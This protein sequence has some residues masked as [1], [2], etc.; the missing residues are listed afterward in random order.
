MMVAQVDAP[1]REVLP[2]AR[3]VAPLEV[4]ELTKT[5]RQGANTVTALCDFS[6]VVQ[7]DEFVAIMGASGSGKSTLL[8]VMAGIT[9]PDAGTVRI[10]GE[11]MTTMRDPQLTRFR[12]RHIGLVFQA[13]NLI[14]TLSA[15]DNVL[16]PGPSGD[17][18]MPM[19][20]SNASVWRIA[21]TTFPT[22]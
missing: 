3:A 8:N 12:R 9:R 18:S 11:E 17:R 13:F 15:R 5:F 16:L 10:A 22:R 2:T 19:N 6:L 21:A 20:C 4:Q 1:P 7:P 14:P